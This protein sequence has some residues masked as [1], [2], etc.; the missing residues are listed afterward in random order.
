M[1]TAPHGETSRPSFLPVVTTQTK[2]VVALLLVLTTAL[3]TTATLGYFIYERTL[4]GLSE[5]RFA[6]IG[7]E[8]KRK[9][10]AGLDLGLPL[11]ELENMNELLRQEILTDDAL[12]ALSIRNAK[13]IILFDTDTARIGTRPA[14]APTAEDDTPDDPH[15]G[16]H[17]PQS[18]IAVP[19]VNSFGKIVGE[20]L[21][22]Y[23]KA[24]YH[25]KRTAT[26][27]RLGQFT[28]IVLLLSSL[29]GLAG[30][31][32]ISRPLQQ[33]VMRL[34]GAVRSILLR[35]HLD[36]GALH[37]T[38]FDAQIDGFERTVMNAVTALEHAEAAGGATALRNS[39]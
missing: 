21:V 10:E 13:G 1:Q 9:V 24:Y 16:G 32:A 19:L 3:T 33:A 27:A 5:N 12:V 26:I 4:S 8:L 28:L 35:L 25:Q 34:E 22:S 23:S 7:T 11:G 29:V 14:V 17:D 36:T 37:G 20:L 30:V 15:S 31:L 38:D 2:I 6:F 39:S 18:T